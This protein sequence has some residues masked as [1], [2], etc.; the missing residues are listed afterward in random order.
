M[1]LNDDG[2]GIAGDAGGNGSEAFNSD[3][4]SNETAYEL[5]SSIVETACEHE[6]ELGL[7]RLTNYLDLYRVYLSLT[8]QPH[9]AICA[10]HGN[11][12]CSATFECFVRDSR[13]LAKA[14]A[15]ATRRSGEKVAV[16]TPLQ[17]SANEPVV[18]QH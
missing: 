13:L 17:L 11:H 7:M 1:Q 16:P 6:H 12:S 10:D 14:A 2:T 4:F 8:K 15:E 3:S 5:L 9:T 18:H